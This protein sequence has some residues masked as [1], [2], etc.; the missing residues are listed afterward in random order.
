[1]NGDQNCLVSYFDDR[2]YDTLNSNPCLD[3]ESAYCEASCGDA[4]QTLRSQWG[5]CTASFY[6]SLDYTECDDVTRDECPGLVGAG[7]IASVG[8]SL[9]TIFAMLAAWA[10]AALL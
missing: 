3:S 9:I 10:N 6:T 4:L 2:I 8:L 5:C 7:F 1:M